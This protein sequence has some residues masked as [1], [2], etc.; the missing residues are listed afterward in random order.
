MSKAAKAQPAQD[1]T[2]YDWRE[3]RASEKIRVKR[4]HRA[5]LI[6]IRDAADAMRPHYTGTV[7]TDLTRIVRMCDRV[8]KGAKRA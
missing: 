2:P 1:Q 5:A 4:E 7:R 3:K 8:V 6:E